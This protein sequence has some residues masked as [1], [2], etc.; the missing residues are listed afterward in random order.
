MLAAKFF[1]DQYFNNPYYAKV[2]GV[3]PQEMNNLEVE[4]LFMA[5]F[6]LYVSTETYSQYYMEL[7]NHAVNGSCHCATRRVPELIIPNFTIVR[8]LIPHANPSAVT[9]SDPTA[10]TLPPFIPSLFHPPPNK[11]SEKTS[12]APSMF[13]QLVE[14]KD[15]RRVERKDA[16]PRQN[17]IYPDDEDE[18]VGSARDPSS[19]SPNPS[20]LFH[21]QGIVDAV[22][23]LDP[24]VPD[25]DMEMAFF[26]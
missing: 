16:R 26:G 4:F 22:D 10:L 3:P 19:L 23:R 6:T 21:M 17:S 25:E 18:I 13:S 24:E 15:A 8:Q 12:T 9:P 2:G 7:R 20:G 11:T 1:D 14:R 5:N